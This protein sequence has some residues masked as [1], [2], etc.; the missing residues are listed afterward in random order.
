M[1]R[2][3]VIGAGMGGL[4]VAARLAAQN[5]AVSVVERS[6]THGGKVG[7]YE[8]DGFA[9]DTGPSLLTLPAVYRD[10]FI[11]TA[12]SRHGGALEDHVDLVPV[13]PAFHYRFPDGTEVD[14]PDA[15]R[16]G[17]ARA[18]DEALG[19][20]AAGSGR[21]PGQQW[22][23]LL[24][25]AAEVWA[26]TRVPFLHRP[27]DGPATLLRNSIRL[28]DL[29]TVRPFTTLRGLGRRYLVDPRLRMLL[30]RYA[31]YSG[32]D[33]RSA[34]A[35]LVVVPYV[36]QA[37]GAWHV[38]GGLRNLADAV[39]TRCVELGVGFTFGDAVTGLTERAGRVGGVRLASGKTIAADIV[40]SDA[41]AAGLYRELMPPPFERIASGPLRQLARSTPSSSAFTLLLALEGRT[42]GMR[43]HT[44]LFGPDYDA[45]FDALFGR[46]PRLPDDPTIYVCAPD[47]PAMRPDADHESWFVLVNAPRHRTRPGDGVDW[48]EP[49]LADRYA[50]QVLA[51]LAARGIDVRDRILWREVRTPADLERDT[52]SPGGSI[53]GSSSNGARSAFL[54]PANRSPVPGLFL[55][56]GSSH[57]GGGLPLVALSAEIVAEL[58]GPA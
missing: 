50:D 46:D 40:V 4:A 43:H 5:H 6:E 10:L 32:S 26:V 49:G 44:V 7:R 1:S 16:D 24:D 29:R 23:A 27:L 2:V 22:T 3:V 19:G 9:F 15:S 13:D 39:H 47:D 31:T 54:R 38:R 45:E 55:V 34:P 18:F 52:A 20:A 35:A 12:K 42:P 36:E 17:A 11:T 8:C 57:P 56:G 51:L 21:S 58:I 41:D 53:Y 37:F 33:P 14:L 25:H 30:D 48:D 28:R